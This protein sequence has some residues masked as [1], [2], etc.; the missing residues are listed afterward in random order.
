MLKP[1]DSSVVE[2][3]TVTNED[4]LED[5]IRSVVADSDIISTASSLDQV[6]A[7][8]ARQR[9]TN[10]LLTEDTQEQGHMQATSMDHPTNDSDALSNPY[11]DA[12]L[13][14]D[15]CNR[16][17]STESVAE[18]GFSCGESEI[19]PLLSPVTSEQPSCSTAPLGYI[20]LD[21][22]THQLKCHIPMTEEL[23][24]HL[25]FGLETGKQM[26]SDV[27]CDA[28]SSGAENVSSTQ[29]K[30]S[31]MIDMTMYGLV[32]DSGYIEN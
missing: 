17:T 4:G 9:D 8:E 2:K 21:H 12:Q 23:Q 24:Q 30:E 29:A 1:I 16:N 31:T 7:I 32:S 11:I 6:V 19:V 14:L 18:H 25:H 20:D 5:E 13:L 26:L 28:T 10:C 27:M 22:N 15:K 3:D